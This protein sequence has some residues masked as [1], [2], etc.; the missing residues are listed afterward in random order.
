[1]AELRKI[2]MDNPEI[3]KNGR[4]KVADGRFPMFFTASGIEFML[5]AI[6][7]KYICGV[8]LKDV[9]FGKYLL[10]NAFVLSLLPL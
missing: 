1:M 4:G 8:I 9:P 7:S 3:H 10:T 5:N 2:T 6:S